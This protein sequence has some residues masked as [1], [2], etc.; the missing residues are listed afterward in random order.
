MEPAVELVSFV[1]RAENRVEVLRALAREPASRRELQAETDIPR[2]TLSRI[3][4][5]FRDRQLAVREG[6]DYATTRLGDVLAAELRSVFEAVDGMA[7][8]QTL[9]QWL[10]VDEYDVPVERLAD[11]D[12]ILPTPTDPLA[13]IRRAEERL[14]DGSRVRVAGSGII[15]SCLEAVWRA[16]TEGRQRLETVLTPATF[17]TIA[18]DPAMRRQTLDLFDAEDASM[19]VHP[20]GELPFLFVV[21]DLAWIAVTDD[22]GTIQ[23]HVETDD[24]DVRAWADATI[25]G[26]VEAAD[27]ISPELL[28]T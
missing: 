22:A 6:H 4:S 10:E 9:Q 24:P 14:A 18:A 28:T 16:V 11:A 17:D 1:I 5:D 27:P 20:D 13:P 15:P 23:G 12:V 26:Y 7:A 25:D 19:A 2:A 3:L 21:D 8:L